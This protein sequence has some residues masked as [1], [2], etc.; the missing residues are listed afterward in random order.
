MNRKKLRRLQRAA[1]AAGL[2]VAEYLA[3]KNRELPDDHPSPQKLPMMSDE[4]L[5]R[6]MIKVVERSGALERIE[7]KMHKR[8]GRKRHLNAKALLVGVEL[9]A[10]LMGTYHRAAVCSVLNGLH[11]VIAE[12]LGLV[13][14]NGH[15]NKIKYKLVQSTLKW[16]ERRLRWGWYSDGVRCD[17]AWIVNAMV[18]A[19]TPRR[20]RRAATS[21]VLDSTP[22]EGY[23]ITREFTKQKDLN[24]AAKARLEKALRLEN[25]PYAQHRRDVLDKPDLPEPEDMKNHLAAVARKL[26]IKVGRDGRIIRGKDPDMRAGWASATKKR[27]AHFFVGYDL[28]IVVLCR[29]IDWQGN[30]RCFQISDKVP[31]YVMAM[32][33]V[34]AGTN[35][36]PAGC[37]A[38]LRA[39]AIAPRIR[40]VVADRAY[41]VKRTSFLRPLHKE[42]LN[43]V[44]DYPKRM[45]YKADP[46]TLGKRKQPAIE[47][48][49]TI[50]PDWVAI[51]RYTLPEDLRSLYPAEPD[52]QQRKELTE[53]QRKELRDQQENLNPPVG[54]GWGRGLVVGWLWR[55]RWE[56]LGRV[57]LV[58]GVLGRGWWRWRVGGAGVVCWGRRSRGVRLDEQWQVA[59]A[60]QGG[61]ECCGPGPVAG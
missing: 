38:V 18:A 60:L 7:R 37:D 13:D 54:G 9:A 31:L 45:L 47:N 1:A 35:P 10:Y 52:K 51:D 58:W 41:T 61:G 48:C 24:R 42:G 33:L 3:W 55:V 59:Q 4:R 50:M 26:G 53:Q 27:R 5:G 36:G 21:V 2:T 40:E 43:V 8:R 34:P 28:H 22:V 11:P 12:E 56:G 19:S 49:G 57:G 23:A 6:R 32:M 14:H 15:P 20:V 44:M 25:D 39:C 29:S 46:I 30:P 17:L 16:L